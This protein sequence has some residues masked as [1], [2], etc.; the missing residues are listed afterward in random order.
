MR[1]IL[2][3][4]QDEA[5][6]V[7]SNWRNPGIGLV[8]FVFRLRNHS[9]ER[10]F[11]E[12]TLWHWERPTRRG[13]V[14]QIAWRGAD[15]V[16]PLGVAQYRVNMPSAPVNSRRRAETTGYF[17]IECSGLVSRPKGAS[18]SAPRELR[19][20]S[21]SSDSSGRTG[22][23]ATVT[24]RFDIRNAVGGRAVPMCRVQVAGSSK[25]PPFDASVRVESW[26]FDPNITLARGETERVSFATA[27]APIQ[28]IGDRYFWTY[29]VRCWA[30]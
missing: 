4:F 22:S 28:L 11:P 25:D 8:H 3:V 12:C 27:S 26:K 14:K 5:T 16:P 29:V 9:R 10:R 23:T 17:R 6:V 21:L 7:Q 1:V 30:R 13:R 20:T 15:P 2:T 19:V 18:P 24:V